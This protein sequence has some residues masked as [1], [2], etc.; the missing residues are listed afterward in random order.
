M[1]ATVADAQ[2]LADI[3]DRLDGRGYK[4]YGEIRGRFEFQRFGLFIDRVQ[5][6]PFASPSKLRLRVPMHEAGLPEA[7]R[8]NPIRRLALADFLARSFRDAIFAERKSLTRGS[9]G[10]A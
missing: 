4:S 9:A 7:L 1:E 3:L 10:Q 6:D 8:K 2:A 5:A